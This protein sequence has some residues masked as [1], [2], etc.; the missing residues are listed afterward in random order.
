MSP[1]SS[2][3]VDGVMLPSV[4]KFAHSYSPPFFSGVDWAG[5]GYLIYC[6]AGKTAWAD[7]AGCACCRCF[8]SK[9]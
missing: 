4:V 8:D 9:N 6:I 5:S 7:A 2:V 3:C 1:A